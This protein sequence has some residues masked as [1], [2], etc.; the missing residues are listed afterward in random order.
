MLTLELAGISKFYKAA[1]WGLRNVSTTLTPGLFTL[2]GPNGSG[3]T[4][5]LRLLAGILQLSAGK[6]LFNGQDISKDHSKYKEKLGYLPQEFG[7]YP[8]MTGR[9]F[10]YYIARLKDIPTKLYPTRVEEVAQCVGVTS[11]LDRRIGGWSV[12]LR[13]RLGI[14][15]A[16]LNDPDILILDEPM[17]GLDL[18]EKLFFWNYLSQLSKERIIL[19]SSNILSDFIT[20]SD[21]VLLLVKGELGFGGGIQELIDLMQDKVWVVEVP[22]EMRRELVCK[23]TVSGIDILNR[24]CRIRIVSDSIPDILGIQLTEP[25]LEDAYTYIVNQKDLSKKE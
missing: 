24:S 18:E 21:G 12:G 7:F 2:I 15:Q 17:V 9:D 3:K 13:Q 16:L 14:A 11:F 6:V 20:Y 25:R 5:L 10:L 19:L 23:W 22:A 4:T 8:E 1:S